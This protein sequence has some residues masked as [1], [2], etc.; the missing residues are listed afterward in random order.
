MVTITRDITYRLQSAYLQSYI[1][2]LDTLQTPLKHH[3]NRRGV[4]CGRGKTNRLTPPEPFDVKD[5][6]RPN[7]RSA[8]IAGDG[9]GIYGGSSSSLVDGRRI[10]E[11]AAD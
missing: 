2:I 7:P 6:E 1:D 10:S 3:Y 8:T 5:A 4:F 11:R 9:G